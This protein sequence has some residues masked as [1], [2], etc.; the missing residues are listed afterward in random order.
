MTERKH[1]HY[2][3]PCPYPHVDVYR[4]LDLFEIT[5]PC[6]QHLTKKALC[7]GKRGA[8]DLRQDLQEIIDTAQ[9]KLE[10]MD[11]ESHD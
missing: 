11:E 8:K 5:D 4:V 6:I 3:K 2:F 7:A 1:G 9:R 10:M